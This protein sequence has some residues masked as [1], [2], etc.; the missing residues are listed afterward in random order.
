MF[1]RHPVVPNSWRQ[2]WFRLGNSSFSK[3]HEEHLDRIM[4][5]FS[6]FQSPTV[7]D[8]GVRAVLRCL[9][10]FLRLVE[11]ADEYMLLGAEALYDI[12][13]GALKL[14]TPIHGEVNHIVSGSRSSVATC[15]RFPGHLTCDL[16]KCPVNRTPVPGVDISRQVL[17]RSARDTSPNYF[18]ADGDIRTVKHWRGAWDVPHVART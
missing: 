17:H 11:N 15:M 4:E 8:T 18:Q 16:R 14:V 3:L 13:V 10:S 5:T 12:C 7:S 2:H 6:F 9:E 1:A